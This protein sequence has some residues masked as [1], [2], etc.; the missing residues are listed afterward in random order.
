MP[1]N[2]IRVSELAHSNASILLT[3]TVVA[4]MA[5]VSSSGHFMVHVTVWTLLR[6]W[7]AVP[8]P[9]ASFPR[10]NPSTCMH[11]R[12]TSS[13]LEGLPNLVSA[14]TGTASVLTGSSHMFGVAT[15]GS[16]HVHS[17]SAASLAHVLAEC[18]D[19]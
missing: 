5:S 4:I 14:N 9:A 16:A 13:N 2:P 19:C 10:I 8:T 15:V 12:A 3:G 1:E 18:S 11:V 17:L 7:M 6:R